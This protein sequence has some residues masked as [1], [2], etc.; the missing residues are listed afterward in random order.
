MKCPNCGATMTCG[1]QR[2]TTSNGKVGCNKCIG[3]LNKVTPTT[4]PDNK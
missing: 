3:S 4:K 1:C 2:R